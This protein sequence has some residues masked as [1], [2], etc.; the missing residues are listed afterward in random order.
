MPLLRIS[1]HAPA[2]GATSPRFVRSG[3]LAISIHAPAWGATRRIF[4]S[5]IPDFKFQSTHP[6]GVRPTQT[7]RRT[8]RRNFNPRT[9]MGCDAALKCRSLHGSSNFNPRTRM[10][11]DVRLICLWCIKLPFQST[12]PHGV[13]RRILDADRA[14]Q[15][16]SIHAPAWGATAN[17]S[18][19]PCIILGFQSTHPHGVRQ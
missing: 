10:G 6:H 1:I 9:R 13:R 14:E 5:A 18:T 8:T 7:S 12:H 15:R 3:P 16:I 17:Q 11:C 19:I 2:W 4:P